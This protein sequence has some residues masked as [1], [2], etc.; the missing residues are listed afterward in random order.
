MSGL[1]SRYGSQSTMT[2]QTGV[3]SNGAGRRG[4]Y[5]LNNLCTGYFDR[6]LNAPGSTYF[7]AFNADTFAYAAGT[8]AVAGARDDNNFQSFF[9]LFGPDY[10]AHDAANGGWRIG[11]KFDQLIRIDLILTGSSKT[12]GRA[13]YFGIYS[14]PQPTATTTGQTFHQQSWAKRHLTGAEVT[15]SNRTIFGATAAL[16]TLPNADYENTMIYY[17]NCVGKNFLFSFGDEVYNDGNNN[18]GLKN[19]YIYGEALT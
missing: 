13:K 16:T 10:T 7:D 8:C 17:K 12:N 19:L 4:M 3:I 9:Y 5:L 2:S 11:W 1:L 15:T 14:R 18:A 6:N